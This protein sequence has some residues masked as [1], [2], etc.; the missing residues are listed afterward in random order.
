MLDKACGQGYTQQDCGRRV[1]K[2]ADGVGRSI[3]PFRSGGYQFETCGGMSRARRRFWG[4]TIGESGENEGMQVLH[5]LATSP[6][7]GEVYFRPSWRCGFVSDYGRHRRWWTVWRRRL[8][9]ATGTSRRCL[10]TMFRFAGV[11]V[12][13]GVPGEDERTPEGVCDLGGAGERGRR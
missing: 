13:G 5:M 11:L 12:A 8:W 2:V 1:A 4:R 7:D 3:S 6:A 10:R 9:R